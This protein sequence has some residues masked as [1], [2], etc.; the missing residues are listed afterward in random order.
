M[1]IRK[2][3]DWLQVLGLFGVLA[4]LIFV[5]LQL[6]QEQNIA[7]SN[8]V[9]AASDSIRAWAELVT[10]N[11]ELW[12]RGLAGEPLAAEEAIAF[13][14]MAQ[15]YEG[16]FFAQWRS[17]ELT[18]QSRDLAPGLAREAAAEFMS[19]PGLLEFWREHVERM[20]KFDRPRDWL[21]LVDNEMK[22]LGSESMGP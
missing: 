7:Q 10:E 3:S 2:L 4:G 6:R 20:E 12:A 8:R 21:I 18:G 16:R 19:H 15:A 17:A 11:A 1:N 22:L 9:Q 14:V 5:G 13:R